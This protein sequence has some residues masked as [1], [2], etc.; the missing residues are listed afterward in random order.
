MQ[1][2]SIPPVSRAS[3]M[4]VCADEL[5]LTIHSIQSLIVLAERQGNPQAT[6]EYMQLI[7]T[8]LVKFEARVQLFQ[9]NIKNRPIL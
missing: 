1:Q 7:A 3:I 9:Q 5:I 8:T 2:P 6:A 4:E